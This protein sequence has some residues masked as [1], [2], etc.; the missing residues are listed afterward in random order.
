MSDRIAAALCV[1]LWLGCGPGDDANSI[2][3]VEAFDTSATGF[4]S[5]VW[6]SG[7]DDVWIVGGA[8]SAEIYHD[9][10]A[11][12]TPMDAPDGAGLLV[13]VFGFAENDVFAVGVEGTAL[14]YDGADWTALDPGTDQDLWGVWGATNDDVWIVGGN[15]DSGDPVILHYDGDAITDVGLPPA[16]NPIGA[17]ALFKVF[18]IGNKVW[19]VGQ[20]GLIVELQGGQWSRVSAGENA[21]DDFISLWGTTEDDLVVVGGRAGSRVAT[22]NGSTFDTVKPRGIG[23]TSAVFVEADGTRHVGGAPGYVG[24]FDVDTAEITIDSFTLEEIHGM[25]GD[26]AGTVYAVGGRA[27]APFAGIALVSEQ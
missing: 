22:Y 14:H 11:D 13:W 17:R 16:Q 5:S 10:G 25:W 12:W 4:L 23:G 21:D 26:D 24:R 20:L 6:G 2:E 3:W 9:D 7:P 8:D 19:A 1:C 27:T 15:F 18:G